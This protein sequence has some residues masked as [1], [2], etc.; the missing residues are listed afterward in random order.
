MLDERLFLLVWTGILCA[1]SL[2][3]WRQKSQMKAQYKQDL[4]RTILRPEFVNSL[5]KELEVSA[6]NSIQT[7]LKA[8]QVETD[9]SVKKLHKSSEKLLD[10]GVKQAEDE[11]VTA[12]KA[13]SSQLTSAGQQATT[14]LQQ[15]LT[16]LDGKLKET[17][18][19]LS[20][21]LERYR[22]EVNERLHRVV[23]EQAT[24]VLANYLNE[25]FTGIDLGSQQEVILKR[26]EQNKEAIKKDYHP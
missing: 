10:N 7:S 17:S 4:A 1:I 19:A 24:E 20:T 14:A 3:I 16:Q 15:T 11:L 13:Y 25:S 8:L 6:V 18:S 2:V 5:R 12:A 22:T 23:D 9:E 21:E 26:L